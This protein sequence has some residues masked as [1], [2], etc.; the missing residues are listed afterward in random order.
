MS[1][2]GFFFLNRNKKVIEWRGACYRFK[3]A[4]IADGYWNELS[5]NIIDGNKFRSM[6]VV[7]PY[8]CNRK[9]M[10]RNV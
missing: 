8:G 10:L 9:T 5:I 6:N 3:L 7:Y 1:G 2:K 4:C